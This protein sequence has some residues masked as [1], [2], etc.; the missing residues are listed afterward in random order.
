MSD[1]AE[2][3][4]ADAIRAVVA[5]NGL[6]PTAFLEELAARAEAVLGCDGVSL[7][8]LEPGDGAPLV[9]AV[10]VSALERAGGLALD[11]ICP[12]PPPA[13][14]ALRS[15]QVVLL[16]RVVVSPADVAA[17]PWLR[18]VASSLFAPMIAAGAPL[19]LLVGLWRTPRSADPTL[20][21]H[22]A[23]LAGCVGLALETSRL[24]I[25]AAGARAD[26]ERLAAC[27]AESARLVGAIVSTR[28][29]THELN[30][31]LSLIRGYSAVL[32][33]MLEGEPAMLA[34]RIVRGAE[35]SAASV[36][37]LQRVSGS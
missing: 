20:L 26:R 6:E 13:L 16:E 15:G 27:A 12:A 2:H 30:N 35:A 25:A 7:V 1:S 33:E 3:A 5:G 10:R 29:I 19:G 24:R 17:L 34:E 8:L 22:A 9:R 11:T 36:A 28:R 37:R 4:L 14:A 18:E 31:Q 32:A 21:A 23:A